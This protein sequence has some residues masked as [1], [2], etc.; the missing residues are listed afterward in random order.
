MLRPMVPTLD[1]CSHSYSEPSLASDPT[2]HSHN[3]AV[4][5]YCARG[6]EKGGLHRSYDIISTGSWRRGESLQWLG[7]NGPDVRATWSTPSCRMLPLREP[8]KRSRSQV[9]AARCSSDPRHIAA[10]LETATV[11]MKVTLIATFPVHS[12]VNSSAV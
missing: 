10:H 7:A 6:N 11:P 3:V 9:S 4:R 12:S 2:G 8:A 5:C 1:A